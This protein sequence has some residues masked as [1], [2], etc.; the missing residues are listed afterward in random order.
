MSSVP[1]GSAKGRNENWSSEVTSGRLG[2]PEAKASLCDSTSFFS[3]NRKGRREAVGNVTGLRKKS[4]GHTLKG[5][6]SAAEVGK[7]F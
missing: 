6:P 2:A 5:R 1:R 3:V 7:T 4:M